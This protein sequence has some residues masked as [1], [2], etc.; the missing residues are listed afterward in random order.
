LP[1][2]VVLFELAGGTGTLLPHGE[3]TVLERQRRRWLSLSP[4]ARVIGMR[5]FAEKQRQVIAIENEVVEHEHEDEALLVEPQ[6]LGTEQRS[7]LEPKRLPNQRLGPRVDG[8]APRGGGPNRQ[9][10]QR[11]VRPT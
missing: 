8:L 4:R 11:N 9:V 1:E 6:Q 5:Q 10:T 3:I 7:A 2:R